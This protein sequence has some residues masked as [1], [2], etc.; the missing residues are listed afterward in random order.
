MSYENLSK[1]EILALLQHQFSENNVP[2]KSAIGFYN[3]IMRETGGD[4]ENVEK[5]RKML[6]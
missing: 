4:I 5:L 2:D 6:K 1:E 3:W